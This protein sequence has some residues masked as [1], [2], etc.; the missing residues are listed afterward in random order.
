MPV[1]QSPDMGNQGRQ[2]AKIW[3]VVTVW[4]LDTSILQT[5]V[6][7]AKRHQTVHSISQL[8]FSHYR[9]GTQG[10]QES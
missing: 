2:A 1:G 8:T 5:P 4:E 6:A 3:V 7:L 10:M 9:M